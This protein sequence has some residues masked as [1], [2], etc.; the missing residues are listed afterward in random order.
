MVKAIG[1]ISGGLDSMLAARIM[2]SMNIEVIALNFSSPF[3]T[4]THKNSGC[5]N[6]AKRFANELGL[7]V[8]VKFLG[9]EY[10]DVIKAPKFGYGKHMNPCVDCRIVT[11]RQAKKVMIEEGAS[12]VFT[13]EV[14]GQRKMSQTLQR[15]YLIER[16]AGLQQ[17]IV[18]PLSGK[19]LAPTIPELDGIIDREKMFE[20]SGKSR[21][22]QIKIAQEQFGIEDNL[23]SAG[24]CLLTDKGISDRVKDLFTHHSGDNVS[25]SEA[26]LLKIGRH[27]RINDEVK[28][29]VGR[30]E[31]ENKRL[32]NLAGSDEYI[33]NPES[34][35]GP[36]GLLKGGISRDSMLT[37]NAIVARYSAQDDN[38]S[39]VISYGKKGDKVKFKQNSQR[40]S[41]DMISTMLI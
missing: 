38:Y 30:N 17:Q 21:K 11:F 15:L 6:V 25:T 41:D 29:I 20:L 9:D 32:T 22:G 26:R 12:F 8:I 39:A 19:S 34:G 40:A 31:K 10:L 23:C 18:R 24:G 1:L 27:F 36:T 35:K 28:L 7:K 4:C 3:C 14:V 5:N 33:F 13:G 37:A 16:E 2:L